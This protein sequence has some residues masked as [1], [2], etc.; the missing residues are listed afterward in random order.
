MKLRTL[1]EKQIEREREYLDKQEVGTEEYNNS[2]ERLNKLEDK[3]ADLE[4]FESENARK[5][6]QMKDEKKDRWFRNINDGVKTVSGIAVPIIGLVII[7]AFEKNETFTSAAKG[8][9]NCFIPKKG[10]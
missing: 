9:I 3:L 1:L 8:I 2:T 7:T 4:K 10:F 6:L 5:D